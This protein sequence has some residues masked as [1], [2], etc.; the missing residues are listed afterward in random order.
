MLD[1]PAKGLEECS[2]DIGLW[3]NSRVKLN[4]KR[5]GY[6]ISQELSSWLLVLK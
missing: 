6:G 1:I 5:Y 3:D 4:E 2:A